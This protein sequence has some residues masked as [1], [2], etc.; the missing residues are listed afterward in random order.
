[1]FLGNIFVQ[2][3]IRKFKNDKIAGEIKPGMPIMVLLGVKLEG[4]LDDWAMASTP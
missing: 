1:L 4:K 3:K 2:I